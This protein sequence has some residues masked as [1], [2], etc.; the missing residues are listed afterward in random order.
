M[1]DYDLCAKTYIE[2]CRDEIYKSCHIAERKDI[3]AAV[4]LI[5]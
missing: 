3:E 2:I 4:S 5:K 1:Y